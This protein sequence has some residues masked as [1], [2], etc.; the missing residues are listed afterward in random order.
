MIG[1]NSLKVLISPLNNIFWYGGEYS[2]FSEVSITDSNKQFELVPYVMDGFL[3][4]LKKNNIK[5]HCYSRDSEETKKIQFITIALNLGEFIDSK[6]YELNE[7]ENA[8][9]KFIVIS[10]RLNDLQPFIGK[11]NIFTIF[12]ILIFKDTNS[13]LALQENN[14]VSLLSKKPRSDIT[15]ES[16]RQA[17]NFIF[18]IFSNI[19]ENLSREDI[20]SGF[21]GKAVNVLYK[22]DSKSSAKNYRKRELAL[23][24]QKIHYTPF[25]TGL[26]DLSLYG[27]INVFLQRC[28]YL[29]LS[30]HKNVCIWLQDLLDKN[31]KI[32]QLHPMKV[33]DTCFYRFNVYSCLRTFVDNANPILLENFGISLNVP[34]TIKITLDDCNKEIQKI[35]EKFISEIQKNTENLGYPLIIKP[36]LCTEHEMYL[37]LNEDG[38]E[39]ILNKNIEKILKYDTF[40]CQKFIPHGG[41]M[42][43]NYFLNS[44]TIT[45]TRPSLPN[46]EGDTLKLDQFKDGSF[47]FHNEFLYKKEDPTFWEGVKNSQVQGEKTVSKAKINLEALDYISK[48]FVDITGITLFGLDYLY[49]SNTNLYYVLEVNYFPSYRELGAALSEEFA[50]HI[51]GCYEKFIKI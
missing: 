42:Y 8:E 10:E 49:D 38:I 40:I 18:C 1:N 34:D 32:L 27:D 16:L 21:F 4:P 14:L 25:I 23:S 7:L 33:I 44:K 43:K 37:L 50:D 51:I 24:T 3:I 19:K 9:E 30:D 48:L 36:D 41:E 5:I 11:N 45:I 29:Y 13:Y 20:L 26:Y 39:S 28:P 31:D 35:K 12:N 15:I 46:L 47:K 6:I 2:N 17:N 22:F